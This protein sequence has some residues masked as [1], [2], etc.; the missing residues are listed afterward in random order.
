MAG[1]SLAVLGA[2]L[3]THGAIEISKSM[4]ISEW[5]I[6]TMVVAVGTSIPDIAAA[7]HASRKGVTDLA[8]G[9]GIGANITSILLTLGFM[10]MAYPLTFDIAKVLPTIIAMNV[11]TFTLFI[12]MAI[13]KTLTRRGAFLFSFYIAIVILNILDKN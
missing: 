3:L 8:L 10:G 13:G 6:G 12:F 7:Y 4:G 2:E 5:L 1:I 11:L 9:A